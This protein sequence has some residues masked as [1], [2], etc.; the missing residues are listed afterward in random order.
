MNFCI[1]DCVANSD[2]SAAMYDTENFI[3]DLYAEV[4]LTYLEADKRFIFL[5]K[6]KVEVSRNTLDKVP[7]YYWVHFVL[8]ICLIIL[9]IF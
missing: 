9:F 8:Q 3:C 4:D 1:Q 2:C 7:S 6:E 5:L